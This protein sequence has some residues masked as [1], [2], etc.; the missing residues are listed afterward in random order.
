MKSTEET[1]S[2]REAR[3]RMVRTQIEN[4]G[5]LNQMVLNAMRVVP[6]HLFVP[7]ELQE[8]AYD[9]CP[10]PI[11][12]GQTISQPYI[13]GLMTALIQ[14]QPDQRI[15]E[16]GSGSGYQA[17]VL[18]QIVAE[19]YTLE[20]MGSLV[21]QAQLVFE[22]LAIK[23]IHLFQTDGSLGWPDAAPYHGIVLTAAAPSIPQPLLDQLADG[24]RLVGP[25]GSRFRQMLQV[26]ERHGD[27]LEESD[28]IPV[29][30]VPLR[31]QYGWGME[32]W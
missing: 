5:I 32:E 10:L 21:S 14:P 26:W 2:L 13:V 23:N 6:R 8:H 16:V 1:I 24:G 30:F 9:D 17:A 27:R 3:E 12:Q 31:G 18:A 11:G 25:V 29:A 15:L 7:A 22:Q 19:V 20:R 28:T 4:R